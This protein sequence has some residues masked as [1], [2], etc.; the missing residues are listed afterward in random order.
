MQLNYIFPKWLMRRS[1]S[2]STYWDFV[3]GISM[4]LQL[5][6]TLPNRHYLWSYIRYGNLPAIQRLLASGEVH[7]NDRDEDGISTVLESHCPVVPVL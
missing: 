5:P 3:S 4:H 6:R 2:I 1:L 7:P